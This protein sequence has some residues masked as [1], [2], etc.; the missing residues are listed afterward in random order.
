MI[1]DT[2]FGNIDKEMFLDIINTL[3]I[4]LKDKDYYNGGNLLKECLKENPATI[5]ISTTT[6]TTGKTSYY[7]MFTSILHLNYHKQVMFIVRKISDLKSYHL[8]FNDI[9]DMYD[10]KLDLKS[11]CL[12]KDTLYAIYN[13]DELF[14]YVSCLKK[15]DDL[16]K[17]SALFGDVVLMVMEE[18]QIIRGD[19]IPHEPER[20]KNMI[21]TVGRG[22]GKMVREIPTVL[23][24]NTITLLNPHL[25]YF[26]LSSKYRGKDGIIR[27]GNVSGEFSLD[28]AASRLMESHTITQIFDSADNDIGKSFLYASD[29]FLSRAPK[30]TRYLFT[31][32]YGNKTFGIR[33]QLHGTATYC[34][35]NVDPNCKDIMVFD[36]ADMRENTTMIRRYCYS[37]KFLQTA[38]DEGKLYY[39]NME[40]KQI[41]LDLLGISLYN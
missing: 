3:D 11:K 7:C 34:V 6:R 19:F 35:N 38:F 2:N 40:I 28:N 14:S 16:K 32:Y 1:N 27:N 5:L 20:L 37:F 36:P 33:Q 26:G 10:F 17:Y 9:N 22:K 24:G 29:T 30:K 41:M 25:V 21:R 18:Y 31:I 8:I 23:L 12:I 4:I 39:E 15:D 13:G